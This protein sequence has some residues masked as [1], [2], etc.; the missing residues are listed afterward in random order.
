MK[1]KTE[2]A[3]FKMYRSGPEEWERRFLSPLKVYQ[4]FRSKYYN[5]TGPQDFQVFKIVTTPLGAKWAP[6]KRKS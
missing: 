2:Y 3:I 6:G 1:A 5:E 4:L